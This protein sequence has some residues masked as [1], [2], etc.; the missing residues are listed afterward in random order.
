MYFAKTR[1]LR[2]S[3]AQIVSVV[4]MHLILHFS[5]EAEMLDATKH[6]YAR[7]APKASTLQYCDRHTHEPV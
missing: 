6:G 1:G 3:A 2:R 4:D 5:A 7:A